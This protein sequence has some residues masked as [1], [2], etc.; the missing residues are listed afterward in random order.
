MYYIPSF[1]T[2]YSVANFGCYSLKILVFTFAFKSL[3]VKK[4]M[5]H[6]LNYPIQIKS[7]HFY[8]HIPTAQLPWWVKFL[9]ACSRQCKKKI[10]YIWTVHIYRTEDNVQKTHTYTQYTV[11]YK[12][13]LSYQL[14]II[15][16][17]YTIYTLCSLYIVICEGATDYKLT[18]DWL[19]SRWLCKGA[20]DY[21]YTVLWMCFLYGV[22]W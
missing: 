9:W 10:I 18:A 4:W 21:A 19:S 20:T 6:W 12:D 13:I 11:Y 14:H 15:H 22:Q 8:C 17:M 1:L 3:W 16:R 2:S 7:N 5:I